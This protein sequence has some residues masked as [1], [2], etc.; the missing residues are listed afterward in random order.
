L[1]E[2][3]GQAEPGRSGLEGGQ[4]MVMA[5]NA[6]GQ[7]IEPLGDPVGAQKARRQSPQAGW[8]GPATWE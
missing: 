3:R 6:I 1:D 4:Q 7:A 8:R 2:T 5:F